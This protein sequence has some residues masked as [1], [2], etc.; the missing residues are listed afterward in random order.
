MQTVL[1]F[2]PPNVNEGWGTL[3]LRKIHREPLRVARFALDHSLEL[4][5]YEVVSYPLGIEWDTELIIGT[6]PSPAWSSD[7]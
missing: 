3:E 1:P 5:A 6:H 7:A 2:L 4:E